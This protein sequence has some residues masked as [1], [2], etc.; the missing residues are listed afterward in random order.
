MK[1]IKDIGTYVS[2]GEAI[3]IMEHLNAINKNIHL[4]YKVGTKPNGKYT[5]TKLWKE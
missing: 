4:V 2:E 1:K 5:V 3:K